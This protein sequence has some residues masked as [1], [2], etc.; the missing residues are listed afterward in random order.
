MARVPK[1]THVDVTVKLDDVEITGTVIFDDWEGDPSVNYGINVLPPYVDNL[2]VFDDTT[3][4]DIT[5]DFAP[6]YLEDCEATL[7][8]KAI[9]QEDNNES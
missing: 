5:D 4:D 6:E 2:T 8:D 7:I 9:E 1:T 3:G